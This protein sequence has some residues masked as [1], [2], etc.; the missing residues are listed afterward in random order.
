MTHQIVPLSRSMFRCAPDV[1]WSAEPDG[2]RLVSSTRPVT[3]K[4]S[5]PEAA[6]WDFVVR[7]VNEA[8]ITVMI[9]HI[10]GMADDAAA[11]TFVS[12]CLG[13]WQRQ[14]LIVPG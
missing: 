10:G 6:L 4:L 2:I 9:R 13:E 12:R 1:V 3:V 5:Y 7:G 8:R 11:S 14:G